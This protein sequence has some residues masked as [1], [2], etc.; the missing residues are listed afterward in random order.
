MII[1]GSNLSDTTSKEISIKHG[2]K[3]FRID[4]LTT[5]RGIAIDIQHGKIIQNGSSFLIVEDEE[6]IYE[7]E[8]ELNNIGEMMK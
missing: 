7:F 6:Q 4:L 1:N 2:W 3:R 8:K 5:K